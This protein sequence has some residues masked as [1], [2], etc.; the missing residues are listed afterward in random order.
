MAKKKSKISLNT[1]IR[2]GLAIF[3]I[4]LVWSAISW[5]NFRGYI[6][7][8]H[9]SYKGYVQISRSE[10]MGLI[11]DIT[12][13]TP[14]EINL[15]EIQERIETHPYVRATRVSHRF[16]ST[17]EIEIVERVPL[18]V[19][20][21]DPMVFLDE[22]CYVMPEVGNLADLNV[23]ILSNYNP[24]P[25]L[26]PTGDKANSVKVQESIEL[27]K[28][29]QRDYG[30]LYQNISEMSLNTN[31]EFIIVLIDQ[32]T[33]IRLG[34]NNIWTK[35]LVLREF[36]LA[37]QGKRTLTDYAYLDMRYDN[38]VIAKERL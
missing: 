33:K 9:Y 15:V 6:D 17:I 23:P 4:G 27:L 22:E 18:A 10:Y 20:N 12:K 7:V 29:I 26:Y 32:P 13:Q 31:D 3:V 38:Q 5:V 21:G 25:D 35:L 8:S 11:D 37:I 24:N 36:E 28:K 16:P 19:L 34:R 2:F 1:I 14:S 30:S